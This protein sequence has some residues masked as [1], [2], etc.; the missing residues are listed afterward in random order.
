MRSQAALEFLSTYGFAFLVI[1]TVVGS[2]G[3]YGVNN[4]HLFGGSHCVI[5]PPFTCENFIV[6]EDNFSMRVRN[7]LPG[8]FTIRNVTYETAFSDGVV[9]CLD[10][11]DVVALGEES[12]VINCVFDD[13]TH[14]HTI[15]DFVFSY[16]QTSGND[17]YIRSLRG[18]IKVPQVETL[19]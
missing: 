2:L 11:Q 12:T 16:R 19:D 5:A 3:F 17:Q 4:L 7:G 6:R 8:A 10:F 13:P 1:L 9:G 14:A 18:S 15:V